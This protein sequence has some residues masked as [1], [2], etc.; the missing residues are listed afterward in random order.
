MIKKKLRQRIEFDKCKDAN[1]ID[2]DRKY[3]FQIADKEWKQKDG[4]ILATN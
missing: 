2:Y 1:E 3:R 4:T